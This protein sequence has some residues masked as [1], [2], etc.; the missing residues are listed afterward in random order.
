MSCP[1]WN[2]A[3]YSFVDQQIAQGRQAFIVY[4]LVEAEEEDD[5]TRAAVDEYS[6][7]SRE[8]FR[9]RRLGLLHGRM[10]ADEKEA[11]MAAFKAGELDIL[12]STPCRGRDRHPT[13][14]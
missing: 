10:K 6:R 3:R 7:L 13:P 4:P 5:E 2:A 14:A 8:V 1:P 9:T 11:V 12:V